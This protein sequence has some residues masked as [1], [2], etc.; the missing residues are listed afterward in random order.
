MLPFAA[1]LAGRLL[2]GPLLARCALRGRL[3]AAVAVVAAACAAALG[4]DAATAGARAEPVPRGL[5]GR[6]APQRRPGGGLLGGEQHL[7]GQRGTGSRSA[8]LGWGPGSWTEPVP[9]EL[10]S[11][12]YRPGRP[13]RRASTSRMTSNPNSSAEQNAAVRPF[14]P[15][16]QALRPA[17][18]T[19]LVWHRSPW[20]ACASPRAPGAAHP[21][22]PGA[23]RAPFRPP[24]R[25]SGAGLPLERLS[26]TKPPQS[27]LKRPHR[28]LSIMYGL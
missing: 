6:P 2:G 21:C 15:P 20:P 28:P 11:G 23:V 17:G 18:Y 10:N 19:V 13:L 16:A 22:A 7:P 9:R 8:R 3:T 12:W 14:G 5:A 25:P 27:V 1:V 24:S 26:A 4:Y